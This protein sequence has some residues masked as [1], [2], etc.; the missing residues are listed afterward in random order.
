MPLARPG[1]RP[2][3]LPPSPAPA[4]R[5]R[6]PG[7]HSTRETILTAARRQF[8]DLGYGQASMRRIASSSA[9]DPALLYYYFTTKQEL[10]AASFRP[11]PRPPDGTLRLI[12]GDPTRLGE[13]VVRFV[14]EDGSTTGTAQTM[15]GLVRCAAEDAAAARTVGQFMAGGLL[16][17]IAR[18]LPSS[19][20]ALRAALAASQLIGLL[21]SR[22]TLRLDPLVDVAGDDLV[23][24]CAPAVQHCLTGPLPRVPATSRAEGGAATR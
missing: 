8:L 3:L 10:F 4:V 2:P 16:E 7:H 15:L 12:E 13:R 6:R 21:L 20:P 5:G 14:L 19:R 18:S 24:C 23:A 1:S 9:V 17:P 11:P 22:T